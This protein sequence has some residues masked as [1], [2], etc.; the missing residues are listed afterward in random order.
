MDYSFGKT[1]IKVFKNLFVIGGLAFL[2]AVSDGVGEVAAE[3][4]AWA[5]LFVLGIQMVVSFLIDYIKHK[6][7]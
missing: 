4:G 5:P 2:A 6:P 3:L 7:A 1:L